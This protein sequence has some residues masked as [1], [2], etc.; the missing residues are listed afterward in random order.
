[1]L[2]SNDDLADMKARAEAVGWSLSD[3]AR[4]AG[5]HPSTAYRA[6]NGKHE[7]GHAKVR[8][9]MRELQRRE[10]ETRARIASRLA[11]E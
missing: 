1:M 4:K 2:Q 6:I 9:M 10:R 7:I 8:A 3:L 5:V 11:D